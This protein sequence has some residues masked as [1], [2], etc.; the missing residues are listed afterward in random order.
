MLTEK[1]TPEKMKCDVCKE[2]GNYTDEEYEIF[3]KVLPRVVLLKTGTYL[4]G[5]NKVPVTKT[6]VHSAMEYLGAGFRG[7]NMNSITKGVS[8]LSEHE[9]LLQSI[10]SI[11][12]L[13]LYVVIVKLIFLVCDDGR[14]MEDFT[15][16]RK[17]GRAKVQDL[18]EKVVVKKKNMKGEVKLS[19]SSHPYTKKQDDVQQILLDGQQQLLD[20]Q[21][22]LLDGQQQLLDNPNQQPST[23]PVNNN[24]IVMDE[25]DLM[26][27]IPIFLLS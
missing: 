19:L 12:I 11:L 1:E 5:A 2:L 16:C 7:K 22:Q 24:C 26:L 4:R 10:Y 27:G 9:E 23:T 18:D 15:Q 20:V 21:Q 14:G 3:K 6:A 25:S 17:C 13:Y 8:K